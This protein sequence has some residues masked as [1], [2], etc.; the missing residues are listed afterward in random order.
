MLTIRQEQMDFLGR[1]LELDFQARAHRAV[2][3]T[4]AEHGRIVSRE[5]LLPHVREGTRRAA[6][7]GITRECDVAEYILIMCLYM[8]GCDCPEP[9]RAERAFLTAGG[10]PEDRLRRFRAWAQPRFEARVK[11]FSVKG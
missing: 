3:A 4:M 8:G 2:V 1:Q 7:F 9:S 10:E 11:A 5:E 6:R